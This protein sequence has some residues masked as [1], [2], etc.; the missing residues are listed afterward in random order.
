MESKKLV[1]YRH[2]LMWSVDPDSTYSTESENKGRKSVYILL[3]AFI[4]LIY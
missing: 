3:R 4:S 2:Q 1:H